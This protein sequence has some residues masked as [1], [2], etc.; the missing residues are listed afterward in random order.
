METCKNLLKLF[1]LSQNQHI[2]NIPEFQKACPIDKTDK[3]FELVPE[4][5]LDMKE[6][7]NEEI[8]DG[9]NLLFRESAAFIIRAEKENEIRGKYNEN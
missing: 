5:Y 1:I 8:E 7:N 6:P 4:A 3:V 9:I 2:P